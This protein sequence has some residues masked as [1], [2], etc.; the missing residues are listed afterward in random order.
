MMNRFRRVLSRIGP[1]FAVTLF[2]SCLVESY[3]CTRDSE[4]S[5]SEICNSNIGVCQERQCRVDPDCWSSAISNGMVCLDGRCEFALSFGR[6]KAPDFCLEVVNPNS[7]ME[8]QPFC[9]SD[10]KGKVGLIF[11]GLL[12]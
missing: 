10:Q 6:V 3:Y 8:G 12:A 9:L 5:S 7:G 2:I 11:F 1:L 4:C